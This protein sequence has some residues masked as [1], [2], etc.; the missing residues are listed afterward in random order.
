MLSTVD[1]I[2]RYTADGVATS[3]PY[4]RRFLSNS[5][6][7]V[8]LDNVLTTSYGLTGAGSDSGGTV[9]FSVAPANGVEIIIWR[10]PPL[11]QETDYEDFDGNPS[12]VTE[13]AFDKLTMLV[14]HHD[15][16]LSRA[17]RAPFEDVDALA[18]LPN[19][20]TRAGRVAYYDGD[21][22]PSTT[23]DADSVSAAAAAASASL[24]ET[25]R[26]AAEAA[27]AAAEAASAG[28]K[29]RPQVKAATTVN[30][31]LSAPQTIDGVSCIAGD[32]VLVKD[33]AA[34]AE[35]GVYLVAAGAWTRATDAD[36]WDEL[37]SQAV[38]IEQGAT[39]ADSQWICTV[40]SGGTLGVTAVT[41][42][43]FLATPRDNS[44]SSSKIQSGAV[45]NDKLGSDVL[46]AFKDR[47]ISGLAVSNNG[48][49]AVND[50]DIAAG[51]CISDDGTTL[52]TLSG[53]ITKQLDAAWVVGTNQGGRDTGAIS[54]ATWHVWVIKRTDTGV[55]DVLFSLSPSAPTMPTSYTKKKRIA[56]I[57]RSGATILAFR[58]NADDF[59]LSSPVLDVDSTN[60]GTA[61]VLHTLASAPTGI[62]V[63]VILNVVATNG[64]NNFSLYLSSPDSTD[65]APSN[66][67]AP[68]AQW[69]DSSGTETTSAGQVEIWTNTSAQIRTRISA[70]GV[71]DNFKIATVGWYDP[72]Y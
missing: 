46:V 30:I 36:S 49:D 18:T 47:I 24:A 4:P 12:D 55:T 65:M 57:I 64:T 16:L 20:T 58:Q 17:I 45:T 41:W 25:A 50:I 21:G 35:N 69:A 6:V 52:M 56:S 54:N 27:Q 8:T 1:T 39:S 51:S 5:H 13:N 60:P 32:R 42:A 7:N 9:T 22:N 2:V 37:V 61:A 29:W 66:S 63:K 62:R 3:Y 72:R 28:I 34:P 59:I 15:E 48:S 68:L 44:V 19:K 31:T 33:Q 71:A 38:S 70:S 26:V 10:E 67:V 11:T 43:A 23:S 53:S 40:N 14:Q